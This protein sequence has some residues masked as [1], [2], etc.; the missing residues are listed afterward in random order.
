[1]KCVFCLKGKSWQLDLKSITLEQ[2]VTNP[3]NFI[4]ESTL[5]FC[6]SF[7]L[8]VSPMEHY[9]QHCCFIDDCSIKLQKSSFV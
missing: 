4:H 8:Y 9:G 1:M 6:S 5:H 2:F 7:K 3:S